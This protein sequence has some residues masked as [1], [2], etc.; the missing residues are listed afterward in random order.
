MCMSAQFLRREPG[1][2]GETGSQMW[3][4]QETQRAL[5][6]SAGCSRAPGQPCPSP[7]IS[8]SSLQEP[9]A[10]SGGECGHSGCLPKIQMYLYT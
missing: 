3:S 2:E 5:A 1:L 9:S 8:S 6:G 4:S 10:R 7:G